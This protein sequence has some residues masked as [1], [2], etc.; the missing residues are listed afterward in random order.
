MKK[1]A[2]ATLGA[3]VV[4]LSMLSVWLAFPTVRHPM[5]VQKAL[6]AAQKRHEH[7][8]SLAS[9]PA[10]NGYLSPEFLSYWDGSGHTSVVQQIVDSWT[11]YCSARSAQRLP[12]KE[13]LLES[14]YQASRKRFE[15]LLPT[16]EREFEKPVFVIPTQAPTFASPTLGYLTMRNLGVGMAGLA[17]SY[18]AA[19]DPQQALRPLLQCI[20]L[21]HHLSAQG[22]A[23]NGLTGLSIQRI[24]GAAFAG[25]V[26]PDTNLSAPEWQQAGQSILEALTSSSRVT[27]ATEDALFRTQNSFEEFR[28]SPQARLSFTGRGWLYSIPGLMDREERIAQNRMSEALL[29]LTKGTPLPPSPGSHL[30]TLADRLRG[31]DGFLS[32]LDWNYQ[33]FELASRG[34]RAQLLGLGLSALLLSHKV[35][36][37]RF[38][39]RLEDLPTSI[40]AESFSWN[41][42]SKELVVFLDPSGV[43]AAKVAYPLDLY[44]DSPWVS[45]QQ[46]G[47]HYRLAP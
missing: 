32:Q 43:A 5:V 14:E 17:E 38:P 10:T 16:L 24:G 29:A 35:E 47:F 23:L 27:E 20:S 25:L 15:A 34:C 42:Q 12:H 41:P 3:L 39:E 45:V 21:G 6:Q 37:Q 44:T 1:A 7:R 9:D 28:A 13:M 33:E 46:D 26:S 22:T 11:S 4:L 36:H 2:L 30:P 18:L 31:T 40:P 19:G 8:Q